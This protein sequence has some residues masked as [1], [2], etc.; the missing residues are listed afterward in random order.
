MDFATGAPSEEALSQFIKSLVD[1]ILKESLT[2]P[3]AE[4][5]VSG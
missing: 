3:E 4:G 2:V 5:T 1:F